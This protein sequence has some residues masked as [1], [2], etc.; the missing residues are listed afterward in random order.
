MTVYNKP[1][2]WKIPANLTISSHKLVLAGSNTWPEAQQYLTWNHYGQMLIRIQ[3][4]S[5][6][7]K[8]AWS[9]CHK[10]SHL[11]WCLRQNL[12]IKTK[13]WIYQVSRYIS[14]QF[15]LSLPSNV[16]LIS[17]WKNFG[18]CSH[19]ILQFCI[20]HLKCLSS[21]AS[22]VCISRRPCVFSFSLWKRIET[23]KALLLGS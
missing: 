5:D 9:M 4:G 18:Y 10:M 15:G 1:Q 21:F 7:R 19:L 22:Q 3:N 8:I 11:L 12:V 13:M 2:A 23:Q 14:G 16:L 6:F 17:L 20:R